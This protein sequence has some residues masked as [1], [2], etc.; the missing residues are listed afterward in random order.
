M[1][2]TLSPQMPCA[3]AWQPPSQA[4][5]GCSYFASCHAGYGARKG[6]RG[7]LAG[8]LPECKPYRAP[9]HNGFIAIAMFTSGLSPTV[10]GGGAIFGAPGWVTY[11]IS[12]CASV[13][14]GIRTACRHYVT[15]KFINRVTDWQSDSAHTQHASVTLPRSPPS[16]SY[17]VPNIL[18]GRFKN[19]RRLLVPSSLSPQQQQQQ[20]QKSTS[21][22]PP[23]TRHQWISAATR[24]TSTTRQP[25]RAAISF[26]LFHGH[27]STVCGGIR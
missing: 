19:D 15:S 12:L 23:H 16:C 9:F 22:S 26:L 27:A 2:V 8:T 14:E 1:S 13:T 3:S 5:S 20:K 11:P 7:P 4:W 24:H 17:L 6:A 18:M 21:Y 10:F 25:H